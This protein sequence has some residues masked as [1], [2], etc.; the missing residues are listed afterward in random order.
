ME[1]S[2]GPASSEAGK[3][4]IAREADGEGSENIYATSMTFA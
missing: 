1:T 3:R 4:D 2:L